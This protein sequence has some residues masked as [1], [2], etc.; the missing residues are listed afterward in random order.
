MFAKYL[1]GPDRNVVLGSLAVTVNNVCHICVAIDASD[2][3]SLTLNY[4]DVIRDNYLNVFCKSAK[5]QL[6][7]A[8][9]RIYLFS[10]IQFLKFIVADEVECGVSME[11]VPAAIIA[12]EGWL[13]NVNPLKL[14]IG[15]NDGK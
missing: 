6:K 11:K 13:K 10:I 7:A 8:S 15:K 14:S 3:A 1:A 2:L 9:I 4:K 5:T 12:I